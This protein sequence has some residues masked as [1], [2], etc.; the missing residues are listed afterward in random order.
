MVRVPVK[1]HIP[2]KPAPAT[3]APPRRAAQKGYLEVYAERTAKKSRHSSRSEAFGVKL[4]PIV[5]KSD[6]QYDYELP[7][8]LRR[9]NFEDFV[10]EG[11][12]EGTD[13]GRYPDETDDGREPLQVD[14]DDDGP[15][16]EESDAYDGSGV[17]P[18]LEPEDEDTDQDLDGT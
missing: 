1:P 8:E 10:G 11:E 9:P 7:A 14:D 18:G 3:R 5:A 17:E 2:R 16:P 4:P 15:E 6:D 13:G 12:P